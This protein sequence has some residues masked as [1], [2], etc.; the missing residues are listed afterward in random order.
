MAETRIKSFEEITDPSAPPKEIRRFKDIPAKISLVPELRALP[1]P[2]FGQKWREYFFPPG[3]ARWTK[4][5]RYEKFHSATVW[6][7]KTALNAVGSVINRANKFITEVSPVPEIMK[8]ASTLNPSALKDIFP[9]IWRSRRAF[10]PVPGSADELK[11]LGEAFAK[12]WY[13][14]LAGEEPPWWYIPMVDIAFE[15]LLISGAS[16]QRASR[17]SKSSF[18][19]AKLTSA[20][21]KAAKR[22]FATKPLAKMQPAQVRA[23]LAKESAVAVLTKAEKAQLLKRGYKPIQI[24][25]MTPLEAYQVMDDI[26]MI[27]SAAKTNLASA[28]KQAV[29]RL[30]AGI[31]RAKRLHPK[32]EKMISLE[33]SRRVAVSQQIREA[34]KGERAVLASRGPLKGEYSVP[35]FTAPEI[36]PVD[37]YYLFESL[38]TS[39]MPFFRYQNT[40]TALL[41][42]L[43]GDMPTRAETALLE[44]FYGSGLAKAILQKRT[45]GVKAWQNTLDILNIPRATLASW[46]LSFPLRQGIMLLP[47]HP[48][49]WSRSFG[50][51]MKSAI[52]G[53][54]GKKYARYFEDM[55]ESSRYA[56]L[57]NRAG[58]DI[59]QWGLTDITAREEPFLS[60]WA[61]LIP[62]VKWS[63]RT[64]TTMSNQLRINIFDDV[65]RNWERAG[66]SWAGNPEEYTRLAA[67]LNHATGR[68]TIPAKY[69]GI[70]P[71][72]NAFFFSPRYQ[73]S[74]PQVVYDAFVSIKNP[75]ARKV[76]VG[77]LIK[78]V[79]TGTAALAM[80]SQ[81]EGVE[82]ETDPRSNE[83]GKVKYKNTRYDF[84]A[85]YAQI[86]RLIA[87]TASGQAIPK[88][89]ELRNINSKEV[90]ERYIRTK[91][92]PPAG[93]AWDVLEGQ[94]F[95]GD[96]MT[97]EPTFLIRDIPSRAVPMVMQDISD[98]IRFQG[99]DGMLPVTSTTA[100][101]GLGV[102]TW[103][104]SKWELLRREQDDLAFT[105]YGREW[106][107][108][109]EIQQ[110][111]LQRDNK[112]LDNL[113]REAEYERTVFPFLEEIKREQMVAGLD[114][115]GG[116]LKATQKEM[117]RLKIRVG[118]LP[119]TFGDWTLNDER[120][121]KYK[122]HIINELQPLLSAAM[123]EEGWES[124]PDEE[125][126][127]FIE[128]AIEVA[129][130]RARTLIRI[131]SR[132][133]GVK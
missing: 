38:R 67:F 39:K 84:W 19:N 1:E 52:P 100:F 133:E 50:Q 121:E 56:T 48:K 59:T 44:K 129:K 29:D 111:L 113:K 74:R 120:Y 85:G 82:V 54:K 49:Q 40:G 96:K 76:I 58:L 36:L 126:T 7:A 72:L 131:E 81:I 13:E 9:S 73:I 123:K 119:R 99:L 5:D 14:P 15:T 11:T 25:H 22:I 26:P 57:R 60:S 47:G 115:E 34:Q 118:S 65:A 69:A 102:G 3:E 130:S 45:L 124:K 83:F 103:E 106:D 89:G 90:I 8:T 93:L 28:T 92:S 95:M 66:M 46:D 24:Q 104:V 18:T 87:Q 94:T 51:M 122:T 63:N 110:K 107:D 31:K 53:D 114:V 20:E 55:A 42:I 117:A 2:S 128:K 43:R 6:P 108:L 132:K 125:K 101:F 64:F 105:T 12:D 23:T 16:A 32:K 91:L 77:D 61:E 17:V 88:G 97:L 62:G 79:G 78:F 27:E 98:A 30:T 41:K 4:P 109:N 33:K 35:A 70:T 80:L 127:R 71:E 116:L 75:A 10:Y 112:L 37:R 68:G 86:A 21:I